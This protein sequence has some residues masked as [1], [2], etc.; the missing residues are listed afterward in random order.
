MMLPTVLLFYNLHIP[1]ALLFKFI[2][3][4]LVRTI[5]GYRLYIVAFP[6]QLTRYTNTIS[7][8]PY[9]E[10][11]ALD[12]LTYFFYL[13]HTLSFTSLKI[14]LLWSERILMLQGYLRHV[15]Q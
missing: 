14:T 4:I 3:L 6:L 15:S 11:W 13:I 8:A 7:E 9:N 10:V 1:Y 2:E 12:F 5:I